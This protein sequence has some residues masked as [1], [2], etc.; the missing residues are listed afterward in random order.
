MEVGPGPVLPSLVTQLQK[1]I[2]SAFGAVLTFFQEKLWPKRA[3]EQSPKELQLQ[4]FL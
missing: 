1:G 2:S 4:L 3:P